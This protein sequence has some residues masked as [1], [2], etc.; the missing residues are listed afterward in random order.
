MSEFVEL[1]F[2]YTEGEYVSAL[3]AYMLT[4]RR[5]LFFAGMA[6][7]VTL[8]G[9]YFF[10]T[11]S[12]LAATIAFLCTGTF[13]FGLIFTSFGTVPHWRFRDNPMFRSEYHL[14]F[15]E[16]E[17]VFRTDHLNATLKWETYT[18]AMETKKFFLLAHGEAALTVIPKRVFDNESQQAQFADMLMR[19]VPSR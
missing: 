15:T 9:I 17:I 19:K 18:K 8:L 13:M 11:Q 2:R 7:V 1:H 4:K 3:R 12:E 5:P 10:L 16:D 14:Q 6:A